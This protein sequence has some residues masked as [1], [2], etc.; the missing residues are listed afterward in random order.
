MVLIMFELTQS[1]YFKNMYI[2]H[3]DDINILNNLG[4]QSTKHIL[5]FMI[6]NFIH[7]LSF[8]F[9]FLLCCIKKFIFLLFKKNFHLKKYHL[10]DKHCE[11]CN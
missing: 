2:M 4:K 7:N 3:N 1:N 8:K 5:K 6:G 10:T 9:L 11:P